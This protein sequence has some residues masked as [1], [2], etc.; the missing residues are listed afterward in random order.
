MFMDVNNHMKMTLK[1][2]RENW[3]TVLRALQSARTATSNEVEQDQLDRTYQL[4]NNALNDPSIQQLLKS[5]MEVQS[6]IPIQV[7]VVTG[8]WT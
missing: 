6:N 7:K 3:A 8:D 4:I 2:P 1:L 5:P